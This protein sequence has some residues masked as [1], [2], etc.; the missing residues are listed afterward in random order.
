MRVRESCPSF[1]KSI[2]IR[3]LRLRMPLKWTN[4]IIQIVNGYEENVGFVGRE[5]AHAHT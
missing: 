5:G 1:S 3:C 4:P 2:H